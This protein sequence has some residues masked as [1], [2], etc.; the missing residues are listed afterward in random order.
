MKY[1]F[2]TSKILGI[3]FNLII[4]FCNISYSQQTKI[5]TYDTINNITN[6]FI[7]N[8][9]STQYPLE[10]EVF[11]FGLK[12][13]NNYVCFIDSNAIKN[14]SYLMILTTIKRI[15]YYIN[16]KTNEF[17]L[18]EDYVLIDPSAFYKKY[19]IFSRFKSNEAQKVIKILDYNLATKYSL[20]DFLK[21]LDYLY[22][23]YF[24][25]GLKAIINKEIYYHEIKTNLFIVGIIRIRAL[26]RYCD[27]AF[28]DS[29]LTGLYIPFALPVY[30]GTKF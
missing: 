8:I 13:L 3:F 29:Y 7:S 14:N 26:K 9:D 28:E 11:I 1:K 16:N 24:Y 2:I 12:E 18:F 27:K 30:C 4:L 21:K 10:N 20:E 6:I 22:C 15:P 17:L 5:T 19:Y 25:Y 23:D